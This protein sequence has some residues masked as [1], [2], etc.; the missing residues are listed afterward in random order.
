MLG[1]G[2]VVMNQDIPDNVLVRASTA[3]ETKPNSGRAFD[4]HFR[5]LPA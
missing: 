3:V 2:C 4:V 1:P 5:R